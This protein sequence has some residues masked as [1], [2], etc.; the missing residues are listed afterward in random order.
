MKNRARIYGIEMTEQSRNHHHQIG[1]ST[2][3]TSSGRRQPA[4]LRCCS[5]RAKV[6]GKLLEVG[7]LDLGGARGALGGRR[8]GRGVSTPT[9][10]AASEGLASAKRHG[11]VEG[12]YLKRRKVVRRAGGGGVPAP[13][14]VSGMVGGSEDQ[15]LEGMRRRPA[16]RR[17][18]RRGQQRWERTC[19]LL[20]EGI[21][22]GRAA[23]PFARGG[24]GV[25]GRS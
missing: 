4:A 14:G 18:R 8:T 9:L 21:S 2:T 12:P 7:D 10:G 22:R 23:A 1:Q 17:R 13:D 11:G 16:R 6:G 3:T 25:G 24:G 15:R 5:Q 20:F 19:P